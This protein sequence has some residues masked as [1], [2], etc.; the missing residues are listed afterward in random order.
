MAFVDPKG[1]SDI[2]SLSGGKADLLLTPQNK[3]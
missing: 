3:R 2:W 1:M